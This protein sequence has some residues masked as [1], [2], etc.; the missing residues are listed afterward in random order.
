MIFYARFLSFYNSL[1]LKIL[2]AVLIVALIPLS[3]YSLTD[4]L[5]PNLIILVLSISL[6]FEIFFRFKVEKLTPKLE[7][8]KN[9]LDPLDS[10]TL[11]ALSTFVISNNT[12]SLIENLFKKPQ[13]KFILE[14]A[15][16]DKKE[17]KI[18]DIDQK[19]LASKA[20]LVAKTVNG[21]F[22]TTMD[23]ITA[24]LLIS[25][26]S[27]KLLF[28]KEL[29][30]EDLEA[31]LVWARNRYKRE[32]NPKR[33]HTYW[34]E[35]I[36]ED[37]VYGWTIETKK[38]MFDLTS[39]FISKK[40]N[41]VG[42]INEYNQLLESLYANKSTILVGESGSGKTAVVEHLARESFM[43]ILNG[44]LFHQRILQLMVDAFMAGA[45]TQGE[46]EERLDNIIAEVSHSGNIIV[47]IPN[48]DNILGNSS[49]NLN[50]SGAL[51]PYI[52][53]GSIRIVATVTNASYKKFVE[54]NPSFLENFSVIK[55]E[56][57][58]KGK[59]LEVLFKKAS[60]IEEKTKT[61]LTYKA[62]LSAY[63]YANSYAKEKVL[64]GS[65]VILLEDSANA[66]ALNKKRIV[67]E[68]D[69]EEQIKK[70]VNVN[71][72]K[73]KPVE[74]ELLLNLENLMH[75][76]VIGQEEAVSVIAEAI[77]RV[78]AGLKTSQKPISFL[79]LGPTGVGKTETAKALASVYFGD[80]KK[81]IRLD[82][83]EFNGVDG[84]KRLLGAAP[85]QGDEKGQL[86]ESIYDNPYSMILLDE[87]EKA[88]LKILDLFLQ[89]FDDGRLTDNKGKTVSFINSI[90]IA[91]SNAA[92]EYIREQVAKG[93]K[94]DGAFYSQLLEYLQTKQIFKPELLNRFDAIIVFKPL[95]QD[96]IKE[97]VKILLLGLSQ[98]LKEKDI[99][100]LFDDK[101]ITKITLEGF[102]KDFGARPLRRFIQNNIEDLIAQKM[103]KDEIKRGDR[104][105]ISVDSVNNIVVNKT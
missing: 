48:I 73:P 68:K 76:R 81:M 22:V 74:K 5:Y 32:E 60:F 71:V 6:V 12:K 96:Q 8:A 15:N 50:I 21:K 67:E 34:G 35:G 26:E 58:D 45:K 70:K 19:E 69:I 92:S 11:L 17:L 37:W 28:T 94:V 62:I 55:F 29:K 75:K 43:G 105:V 56:N 87:F 64:P 95:D 72:G 102:D 4:S 103:L 88:D 27:S 46:L 9:A 84:E 1:I 82:M 2:R 23:L 78:R 89:V 100:V 18:L 39:E 85:G 30:P 104:I 98:N 99:T 61:L 42:R 63:T 90:I 57:L 7:I 97:V 54:A 31:I 66:I 80:D 20:F 59:V 24:Y 13:V 79:F 91:T 25:E 41:A 38:Y 86:T 33:V 51:I 53:N 16:I 36:A 83:S 49:F 40:R 93:V 14:K 10:F 3:I 65:A 101:V 44:N 52:K 77:R 47:Y